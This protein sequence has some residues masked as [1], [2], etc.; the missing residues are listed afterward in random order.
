MVDF[1]GWEMPVQY[2]GIIDEHRAVRTAAGLFD[3]S[4]MGQ[5]ALS[6]PNARTFLNNLLTNDICKLSIGQGHY[7][8]L[9]NPQGGVI[10]DLIVYCIAPERYWLII[11]ASRAQTDLAWISR[12]LALY[13][14][15][16]GVNLEDFRGKFGAVALQGPHARDLIDTCLTPNTTIP[17]PTG[18]A[19][20]LVKN[21][22]GG[23][24]HESSSVWVA[25]TGYTGE[26]G[27]EVFAPAEKIESL[28]NRLLA[29]GAVIGLKPAGLGARD[30]LRTEAGYP[31]YGHELDEQTSPLEAG[32]GRFVALGKSEF[33]GREALIHQKEKGVSKQLVGFKMTGKSAPP[34]PQYAIWTIGPG[35]V[36]IG[37]VVSGTQSP[38]LGI[39]IGMAYV[40][41]S[42]SVPG[43]PLAIE[44]RGQM[45]PAVVVKRP[46]Y[47]SPA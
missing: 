1:G 18:P 17:C 35:A 27:F 25:C 3:I 6:G 20:R 10:D 15:K 22:I 7:T 32:L 44:I 14:G 9:C 13:T 36:Q 39:G 5:A 28:W 38:S 31:L 33:I 24:L 12:Q 47:K 23:Y 37:R 16:D 40:P 11:N 21:Q 26:D 42:H 45:A 29:A 4:H 8:L 19:S 30:T 46:I 41:P 2:S 43:T 34:R